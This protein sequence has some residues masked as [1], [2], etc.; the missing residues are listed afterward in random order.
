MRAK[1]KL[2]QVNDYGSG[3]VLYFNCVPDG[4]TQATY[5]PFTTNASGQFQLTC[6]NLPVV[7]LFKP[8]DQFFV[9]FAPV[10]ATSVG[11]ASGVSSSIAVG[12]SK[13]K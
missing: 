10:L 2:T 7:S 8:G 9:E 11:L 12:A 4:D 1:V 13:H 3:K 6:D 5:S